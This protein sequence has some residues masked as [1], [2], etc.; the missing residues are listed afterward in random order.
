MVLH[1]TLDDGEIYFLSSRVPRA[2]RADVAFR[3]TGRQPELWDADSGARTPLAFRMEKGVTVVPITFDPDGS[4]LIVFRQPARSSSG[5]PRAAVSTAL[6]QLDAGWMLTFQQARGAP[7]G[8]VATAVGSWSDSDVAGIRYFSGTGT[9]TRGFDLPRATLAH[10][11]RVILD[12]GEVAELADVTLNGRGLRT[13]WKPPYRLDIT[14]ALHPG[15]NQIEL[16][17]TNLWV[18]RLIGDEQPGATKI[19]HVAA[20]IYRADA[21]LRRAG[22]LGPVRL[23]QQETDAHL[24]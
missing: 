4:A 13:L 16:R 22:L 14:D 1:R 12:L 19:A 10:G 23:L 2:A 17:I 7:A 8:G 11:R 9:Y 24:P 21:P 18:N 15:R 20:P 3:V 5:Q 6:M